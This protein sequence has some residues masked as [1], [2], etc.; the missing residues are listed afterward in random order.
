MTDTRFAWALGVLLTFAGTAALAGNPAAQCPVLLTFD[1]E[2]KSDIEAFKQLDPPGSCTL[3]V[4]GDFAKSH[5]DV[6]RGWAQHHEIAC[7]TMTHPHL[8]RPRGGQAIRRDPR[9][10]GSDPQSDGQLLASFTPIPRVER[11]N[12]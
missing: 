3:F 10:G 5:P 9:L 12:P 11:R 1:V 6:V 2:V 4:T 7:H 8:A